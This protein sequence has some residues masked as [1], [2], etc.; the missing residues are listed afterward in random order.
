MIKKNLYVFFG[1]FL[2]CFMILI[3]G[4]AEIFFSNVTEFEFVYGEFAGFMAIAAAIAAVVLTLIG[5]VL[6]DK[7]K[8]I[9]LS[10]ILGISLAG[11]IQ[12]M[13]LNKHLDLLG[14]NPDGYSVKGLSVFVNLAIWIVVISLLIFVSFRKKELWKR[15]VLCVSLFLLSVQGVAYGILLFTGGYKYPETGWH[16]SGKDQ[17]TVSAKDNVIVIVLDMFSNEYIKS[18]EDSYPGATECLHDFTYYSNYDC[19]Y[20]GTF[21]SLAHMLTGCELDMSVSTNEWFLNIWESENATNFYNMLQEKGYLTNLYTPSLHVLV[22]TND[23]KLLNGKFSNLTNEEQDRTVL[24][25][26]LYKTMFKVSAY[27]MF[28]EILKPYF[29]T[30]MKEYADI[31]QG[32]GDKVYYNNYGFYGELRKNGLKVD[33]AHDYFIVQ[34]LVGAHSYT[35]DEFGYYKEDATLDETTKGCMVILEE[36]INQLKQLGV[37]DNAAIIVTADHGS[38]DS[39]TKQVIFFVKEPK[40]EHEELQ[41]NDS[42]VSHREFLPTIAQTAGVD[43]T[44]FGQTI[45]DYNGAHDRE[46]TYWEHV[47]DKR[48]PIVPYYTHEKNGTHNVYYGYTYVGDSEQLYLRMQE[49]RPDIV[50]PMV[51]SVY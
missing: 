38:F 31:V 41:V 51:D 47:Y 35:T 8:R 25:N 12:T 40:E 45:Y 33:N 46:R 23:A 50:V 18:L 2:L 13:F 32:V 36:Y 20:M 3:F 29:Y 21:P 48:Y 11:Y 44:D 34:H 6:T 16:L 7:L 28:P 1:C 17:F 27:R 39:E 43:Y 26:L 9:Y 42:M 30:D 5:V 24:Y 49:E 19:T 37:Y 10:V 22:G 4:P 14:M 15:M